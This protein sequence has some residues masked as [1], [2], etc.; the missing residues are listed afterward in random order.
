MYQDKK[1]GFMIFIDK[2]FNACNFI[3]DMVIIAEK[4]YLDGLLEKGKRKEYVINQVVKLIHTPL[5]DKFEARVL[6]LIIDLIVGIFN[7]YGV[8]ERE[9][10]SKEINDVS[11]DK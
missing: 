3:S 1:E 5:G 9:V 2:L 6:S 4:D 8:F 10:Y 11:V 7:K